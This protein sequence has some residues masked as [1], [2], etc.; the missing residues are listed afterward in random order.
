[1][2]GNCIIDDE[3]C[4]RASHLEII[5]RYYSA[6]CNQRKGL[7]E[8]ADVEKIKLLI[9]LLGIE[10]SERPVIEAANA[11]AEKEGSPAAA[12]ELPDGSI[13][14]GKTSSLLGATSA[15]LL[16]ALKKLA[17]IPDEIHL[18][19]PEIIEPVQE[20]KVKHLGNHN[21][22]LHTDEILVALS[23]SAVTNPNSKLALEQL[24]KLRGC[25][26]HSS[27][28]LAP[29]DENVLKKLG[30]NLTSEPM[31]QTKK[32]FHRD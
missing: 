12:L 28:I 9:N 11:K 26:A 13:V 14:T 30:I 15:M 17:G 16:N 21:P 18:I 29:V 8:G 5:R 7:S 4:R 27:V 1:M 23:V 24:D 2:A 10:I 3:A 31:Y 25:E 19:F 20:L 32:L 6:L 22:R